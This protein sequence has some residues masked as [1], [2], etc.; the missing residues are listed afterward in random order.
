MFANRPTMTREEQVG[1]IKDLTSIITNSMLAQ[2]E[3]GYVPDRWTGVELRMYI[4]DQMKS[5][6]DARRYI[7]GRG[8]REYENDVLVR[9][10]R[11]QA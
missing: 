1:F 8:I 5:G 9:D 3:A 2:I 11:R 10:F 6:C 4:T 7:T